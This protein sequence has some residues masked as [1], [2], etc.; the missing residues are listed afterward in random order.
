MNK[1]IERL[2]RTIPKV[3]KTFSLVNIN[4]FP[5]H[6][7]VNFTKASG[8]QVF[9]YYSLIKPID[10]YTIS[11]RETEVIFSREIYKK[12][13]Y[14]SVI[15]SDFAVDSSANTFGV[16]SDLYLSPGKGNFFR[17]QLSPSWYDRTTNYFSVLAGEFRNTYKKASIPP[18]DGVLTT[19]FSVLAGQH[20][21][22]FFLTA[23][24]AKVDSMSTLNFSVLSGLFKIAL[25]KALMPTESMKSVSMDL[26]NIAKSTKNKNDVIQLNFK[27]INYIDESPKTVTSVMNT[28]STVIDSGDIPAVRILNTSGGLTVRYADNSSYIAPYNNFTIN[29]E[30][31]PLSLETYFS[32]YNYGSISINNSKT[33]PTILIIN[34]NG[35]VYTTESQYLKIN[36]NYSIFI[37]RLDGLM[38]VYL[39]D[40]MII[41]RKA[42]F[43][44]SLLNY[45]SV[46]YLG[47]NSSGS[48]GFTGLLTRFNIVKQVAVVT[49][50]VNRD[51]L[52][53]KEYV[54]SELDL[55]GTT[56]KDLNP[57]VKWS[58]VSFNDTI[59][60]NAIVFN[61]LNYMYTNNIEDTGIYNF[62]NY[63]IQLEFMST[64][65]PTLS[66]QDKTIIHK[67]GSS[68]LTQ[69]NWKAGYSVGLVYSDFG[70]KLKVQVG[71]FTM[72]SATIVPANVRNKVEI[73]KSG[74]YVLLIINNVFDSIA[75]NNF[76]LEEDPLSYLVIGRHI[77]DA[78][79][80][81]K[82][83]LYV[84][85]FINFYNSHDYYKFYPS[86]ALDSTILNFENNF[87]VNS[88]E[89]LYWKPS[90]NNELTS[91][92]STANSKFGSVSLGLDKL[93]EYIWTDEDPVF[94]LYN[95]S[96][97]FETWVYPIN[98]TNEATIL[99]NGITSTDI[100]NKLTQRLIINSS[101][102]LQ[103]IIDKSTTGLASNIVLE[104]STAVPLNQWS[105]IA[106]SRDDSGILY[107]YTN[108]N[109]TDKELYPGLNINFSAG[110]TFIG[111]N[112][113]TTPETAQF[114]GYLD[115]L[116]LVKYKALY[117]GDTY[118]VP[119]SPVGS[120]DPS[121]ILNL[122]FDNQYNNGQGNELLLNF[123]QINKTTKL[124]AG[125]FNANYLSSI[126]LNNY[127]VLD[128]E[129]DIKNSG[130]STT[131]V[132]PGT[133]VY[134]SA[135]KKFN[136][137]SL[138]TRYKSF[139]IPAGQDILKFDNDDFTIDFWHYDTE[140]KYT[141]NSRVYFSGN[142]SASLSEFVFTP[143][144]LLK[145]S[146]FGVDL[147]LA[148]PS[149]YIKVNTWNHIAIVRFN[150]NLSLYINGVNHVTQPITVPSN[151]Y[152]DDGLHFG[153]S[154][155]APS[156]Y[157]RG[158]IDGFRI[159]KGTALFTGNFNSD[160]LANPADKL[161]LTQNYSSF[162][163]DTSL[164]GVNSVYFNGSTTITPLTTSIKNLIIN[165]DYS[166]EFSFKATKN[167]LEKQ[168]LFTNNNNNSYIAIYI[169]I[170]NRLKIT[171]TSDFTEVFSSNTVFKIDEWHTVAIIQYKS[172]LRFYVEGIIDS[173]HQSKT[174]VIEF[175]NFTFGGSNLNINYYNG[176]IDSFRITP[177]YAIYTN[178]YTITG[179]QFTRKD[180]IVE[181]IE[182]SNKEIYDD[183]TNRVVA[184]ISKDNIEVSENS[185]LVTNIPAIAGNSGVLVP[186][187][188]V[189]LLRSSD[190]FTIEMRVKI[191]VDKT[192]DIINFYNS[193]SNSTFVIS[194][195]SSFSGDVKKGIAF[196]TNYGNIPPILSPD[197]VFEFDRWFTLA[198]SKQGSVYRI[199]VDGIKVK[200]TTINNSIGFST[201]YPGINLLGFGD[202]NATDK[203]A[204][205]YFYL[206][207][208]VAL[209]TGDTY[210]V[211]N[212]KHVQNY[213]SI[214]TEILSS[215]NN[216]IIPDNT[217]IE[218]IY[219]SNPVITENKGLLKSGTKFDGTN[220]LQ[221]KNITT[222]INSFVLEMW[223]KPFYKN[224]DQYLFEYKSSGSGYI[225]L[226]LKPNGTIY[227]S[228]NSDKYGSYSGTSYNYSYHYDEW[229]NLRVSLKAKQ[230]VISCNGRPVLDTVVES[231]ET[232][233]ILSGTVTL[234]GSIDNTSGYVG[235]LDEVYFRKYKDNIT[236]NKTFNPLTELFEKYQVNV[237][238][239]N[240]INFLALNN[241]QGWDIRS[242]NPKTYVNNNVG[243][244]TADSKSLLSQDILFTNFRLYS[245]T[246]FYISYEQYNLNSLM[247]G[248]L[249]LE[250]YDKNNILVKTVKPALDKSVLNLNIERYIVDTLTP[251]TNYV[252]IYLELDAN[253]YIT[254]I[255]FWVE[256]L[257][258][259][260][261][262]SEVVDMNVIEILPDDYGFTYREI[263]QGSTGSTVES[264]DFNV[265]SA[266]IVNKNYY[267]S[268]ITS[269]DSINISQENY[270]ESISIDFGDKDV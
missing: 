162:K 249:Y 61:S 224:T 6:N 110:G 60:N 235:Y 204:M 2:N 144:N 143:S 136:S 201:D 27:D 29:L 19:N 167:S 199:Y 142:N 169:D 8:G 55:T 221:I 151:S 141:V 108:G 198:I 244:F 79:R 266:T 240:P 94:N 150:D 23:L 250:C 14:S 270:Y 172:N 254:N 118:I 153:S 12:K 233:E 64:S 149:L 41:D 197:N 262:I 45:D 188:Y 107:L 268:L 255:T 119:T 186:K 98:Y 93:G 74:R 263:E 127:F 179:K 76:S 56:I 99:S 227:I 132:T 242:G 9:Q 154:Y 209:Y 69:Q 190:D 4:E 1:N 192:Y 219:T 247:S 117:T 191:V 181:K 49:E 104:S 158:Y 75:E 109:I 3:L 267:E 168:I 33:D 30:F 218:N 269:I 126:N 105:H 10:Y 223:F 185:V 97:T 193:L 50:Q 25:I 196:Y 68:D 145:I 128:F 230:L 225:R 54:G 31:K 135:Y 89:N 217:F 42:I 164:Y 129:N 207:K 139:V 36:T 187:T 174:K 78:S 211:N 111:S 34:I 182:L 176:Y 210:T 86:N 39:N 228:I 66:S 238:N 21:Q 236:Y 173:E 120:I 63:K 71:N 203:G 177:N 72:I 32:L 194:L 251:D 163:A 231:L 65:S 116:R 140:G 82:G 189:P 102:K 46:A 11:Y 239:T 148:D 13:I 114:Y 103:L 53:I 170:D 260:P 258:K 92:L 16:V 43:T 85:K 91:M 213:Y 87:E 216:N 106:L 215:D 222:A 248:R 20:K 137:Y 166:F 146:G 245:N 131:T 26:V 115:S 113:S 214:K 184:T 195:R 130:G 70:T 58:Y 15:L 100:N 73:I 5:V 57:T 28:F 35:T 81:F 232:F 67:T 40:V 256:G 134:S 96:F 241:L 37:E 152:Y 44:S 237:I 47:N 77:T 80:A 180:E 59:S 17:P 206:Y 208:S 257:E 121:L 24:N 84:L 226:L 122:T 101:G 48:T 7:F 165:E 22:S 234:G 159:V 243:A 138:D 229:N 155:W 62:N 252:R 18:E 124:L 161:F 246:K 183:A 200:E 90:P 253:V 95:K 261:T 171:F 147:S 175:S 178:N 264:I 212:T 220:S 83:E 38:Y 123:N 205:D 156:L 160:S 51:I 125:V 88:K 265:E 112:L 259:Q 202:N 133:L 52:N 157:K